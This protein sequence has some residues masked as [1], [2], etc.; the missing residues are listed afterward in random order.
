MS[1]SAMSFRGG[2]D[3]SENEIH[4]IPKDMAAK[5]ATSKS[6]VSSAGS[7]DPKGPLAQ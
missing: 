4:G 1:V 6:V 2:E 5:G 7:T 3:D